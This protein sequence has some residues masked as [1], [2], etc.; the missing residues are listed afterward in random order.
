MVRK[1]NS[2]KKEDSK[3]LEY[4]KKKSLDESIKDGCSASIMSGA[5][6]SFIVPYA[7]A[8]NATNFQIGFFS[9]LIGL[10]GP[11]V[12]LRSSRLMESYSR[13]KI[14][15]L[16]VIFQA[17]MWIPIMILSLMFLF[18]FFLSYLPYL[19][20]LFYI[21]LIG[22]GALSVPA[23]FSW[24]GDL[25]KETERGSYFSRRNK[26]ISFV[27]IVSMFLAGFLLDFFKTKGL[28][29][30]GFALVFSISMIA[31]L[32]SAISL[33]KH[34]EPKIELK[35]GYYFSIFQFSKKGFKDNFGKF[36]L[37]A[38]FFYLA[39]SIASPFFSVYMLNE[40]EFNYF[41]FTLINVANSF[42]G[43][44]TLPFWGKFSDR[45]GNRLVIILSGIFIPTTPFLWMISSSKIYLLLVPSLIGGIFWGAFNLS[46]FNFIYDSVKSEH[47]ALCMT[48]YNFFVGGGIFLGS[49]I[50]GLIAKFV[51]IEFASVFMVIF[52]VS[53]VL[54]A[55]VSLIFLPRIKEVKEVR[56]PHM[57][58]GHLEGLEFISY[59]AGNL[60]SG[61]MY[62]TKILKTGIFDLEKRL[63]S[64]FR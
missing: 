17:L 39:V 25:V 15:V 9:S 19:L 56:K 43:I 18:G 2:G 34:Y 27:S 28:V 29:F 54:R 59:G 11:L 30:I 57:L 61:L 23:W 13:K 63:V 31:R 42:F 38:T 10:I 37:F 36:V 44:L 46:M 22:I 49:I 47:R 60:N 58:V 64:I 62:S 1:K 8:L 50:G 16:S 3:T 7:L 24:M 52:F 48:Y 41:W 26:I 5:G 4:L 45:Y 6:Q 12:Q 53:G 14:V 55:F 20:I 35:E 32:Y 40:L 21:L 51:V 33:K